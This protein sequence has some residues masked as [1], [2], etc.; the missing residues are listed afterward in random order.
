MKQKT[1]KPFLISDLLFLFLSFIYGNLLTLNSQWLN[2]NSASIFTIIFCFEFINF[3]QYY[4]AKTKRIFFSNRL[5]RPLSFFSKKKPSFFFTLM[6][7][8]RG[9]L[10]GIFIEAFKVGS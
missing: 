4:N 1:Y 10:L 7:L 9:A 6:L 3:F 5:F 2:W 8:R